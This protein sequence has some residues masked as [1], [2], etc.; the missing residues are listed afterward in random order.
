MP[1]PRDPMLKEFQVIA[2]K[3]PAGV[4]DVCALFTDDCVFEDSTGV[5]IASGQ[6]DLRAFCLEW[7]TAI[8]DLQIEPIEIFEDGLTAIM[9]LRLRGTHTG[10]PW[11]GVEP[12]GN[13]LSYRAI[14]IYRCNDECTKVRYE[15]L[16]FDAATIVAQLN[17][18]QAAEPDAAVPPAVSATA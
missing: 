2:E 17:G 9:Y 1:R 6:D 10:G 8:P 3:G 13:R 16:A 15:T 14:A 5:E 4:D 7:F 18:D 11:M 12:K